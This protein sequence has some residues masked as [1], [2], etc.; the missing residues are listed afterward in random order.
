MSLLNSINKPAN[1]PVIVSYLANQTVQINTAEFRDEI[2][3]VASIFAGLEQGAIAFQLDNT[4]AWLVID[5][6]TQSAKKV[7]VPIAHFF[8]LQQTQYVLGQCGAQYFISDVPRHELGRH[9]LS[10]TLFE[11]Y[12]LYIY[13]LDVCAPVTYFDNTQKI[14]FTSGST[15]EPKG[16]CLSTQSQMQVAQS[17]CAQININKPTHLCLLPLPVLLE[18]IAGVYAPL[19]SGGSVHLMALAELGFVGSSLK[20]PQQ[21]IAAIDTVQPNT[22]ILVPELLS[23][24]IAFAKQGWQPP[25]S[26]QFIAVGG[27]LVSDAL[28]ASARKY[29]LPVYQGYGLS[30]AASVVSLNT[31]YNDDLN[32]AGTVLPHL[33]TKVERGQLYI[34]GDL[35]L[36]YLNHPPQ[37]PDAWYATGDLVS[38]YNN[39]L[40]IKGRVKNLIITSMGRN[41][42]A[43]WPESLI[44]SQSAIQQAVVFGEG[45]PFLTALI[46]A[47]V[48]FSDQQLNTHMCI[49][50]Q[51]L[52]DYAQVKKW[53]RLAEPLS[54]KQGLLTTNNRAKREPI[55]QQFSNIFEQ[56]YRLGEV[57][58]E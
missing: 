34:K 45:Q 33:K 31:P 20:K 35:F 43:E 26:L 29:N 12:T 23:V 8:S 17:L 53:H 48:E 9:V 5:A 15:G 22:L 27:A 54:V 18:N 24:L 51:Q 7:A 42:S 44:L 30:E 1:E 4:P 50:N 3:K 32:S 19:L 55:S 2:N 52:P 38:K 57:S 11:H 21:L 28:I 36:G 41:V 39:K 40:Y 47:P 16:V 10:V 58:Y 25:K 46:Y 6:A 13:Q 49:I 56:F 14:T 37:H